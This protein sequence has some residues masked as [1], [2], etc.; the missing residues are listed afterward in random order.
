[1]ASDFAKKI[2]VCIPELAFAASRILA[3]VGATVAFHLF[4]ISQ[5]ENL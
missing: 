3:A 2:F 4:A 1:L 5:K